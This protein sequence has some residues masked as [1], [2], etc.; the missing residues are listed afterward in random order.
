MKSGTN[1]VGLWI[2][3]GVTAMIFSFLWWNIPDLANS[4]MTVPRF[5]FYPDGHNRSL[6]LWLDGLFHA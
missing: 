2:V 3:G 5:A 4:L 6:L 1:A